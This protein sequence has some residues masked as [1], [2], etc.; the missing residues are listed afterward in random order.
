MNEAIKKSLM[1]VSSDD[2][3]LLT[4]SIIIA[5]DCLNCTKSREF[6]DYRKLPFIIE[7]VNNKKLAMILEAS[8]TEPL[9]KKDKDFIFQSYSNGLAKRSE[10][11]KILFTLE[12]KGYI[13]LT[14]GNIETLV[15]ITLNKEKLPDGFLS[16]DVFSGEYANCESFKRTIQ[17]STSITLD[18]FLSKVYRDRGI[19]IWEI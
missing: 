1:F 17:R 13:S 6:K 9:H 5:L 16:R 19:K 3:Y 7:I 4:Y 12:K 2:F 10:T 15:N 14:Q 18:T 8:K 11:L